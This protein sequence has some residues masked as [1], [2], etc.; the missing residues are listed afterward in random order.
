MRKVN[1]SFYYITALTIFLF[2]LFSMNLIH[3]T[4]FV[5]LFV[6]LSFF[7][8]VIGAI[9]FKKTIKN[10]DNIEKEAILLKDL[11]KKRIK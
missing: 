6:F 5:T 10:K 9:E 8:L 3:T 4:A 7:V 1:K 11:L 2:I